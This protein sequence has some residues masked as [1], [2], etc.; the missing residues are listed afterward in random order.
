VKDIGITGMPYAGKST[1]FRALTS[2]AAAG[3]RAGKA[4]VDVP[5]Q[6]LVVLAGIER[7]DKVVSAKVRFVDVPGGLTAQG[8][9]EHRQTD[10]L[11][12]VVRAF[13]ADADPQSELAELRAELVLADLAS[14]ESGL[15]KSRKRAKGSDE[16]RIEVEVL[17]RAKALLESDALLRD[18][19][20]DAEA[21]K[22]LKG[23]G[24][25]TLKPWVVVANAPEDSPPVGAPSG[26][27]AI[28]AS[29][30]AE[31]AGMSATEAA[32]LLAGFGIERPGLERVVE[33]CYRALDLLTFL[34]A[35]E[36][37]TRSWEVARGATALEAAGTIHSD[38]QR[39]FIRAEVVA[40]SDLVAA[41]SREGARSKGL[42]RVEG[43]DYVV[44]E[45]DVV[46]IRF[47]V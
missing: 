13:G 25:L 43:K 31:V 14:V 12:L 34:T 39:G 32:E 45:G 6:R 35:N 15:E 9:A 1:L 19:E 30:E 46:H 16:G 22:R 5:D 47:A 23:Y 2:S 40:Y 7:S 26:S 28:S 20:V 33:A 24:L 41:G 36:K 3:G 44:Q 8:L 37:E 4:V 11:C 38:M 10:A 27:L 42:L 21:L 17:E 18:G 29:L